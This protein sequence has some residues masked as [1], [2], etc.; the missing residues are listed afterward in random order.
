MTCSIPRRAVRSHS[1]VYSENLLLIVGI[2]PLLNKE[3]KLIFR[4]DRSA[5]T[6]FIVMYQDNTINYINKNVKKSAL[7]LGI[8][9]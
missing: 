6:C 5:R 7:S 3:L 9:M 8:K 2:G 1:L 4:Y